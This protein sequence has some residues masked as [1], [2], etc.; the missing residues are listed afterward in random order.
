[1]SHA[2]S[3][4]HDLQ[5]PSDPIDALLHWLK[6]A[7]VA[8]IPEH[9]A[10]TLST[11]SFELQPSSRI[12]YFKGF[13]ADMT[14][15]RCP[16]FFTNFESR[17]SEDMNETPKVALLFYWPAQWRQVRIEGRVEKISYDESNTYF[18]TRARGSQ[19]GAW[20]SPQSHVIADRAALEDRVA[21]LE[22]KFTGQ[23]I[24]CPPFWG[25]WRVIPHRF[26]FWQGGESRLHDRLVYESDGQTPAW[27]Q[28][29]IAP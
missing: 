2:W 12:V 14:G 28:S 27:T 29:R 3:N 18:Q 4:D 6:E 24:A 11:V 25:G 8:K 22:K 16:R 1:M 15:Q 23:P 10:M 5:L 21:E 26:E 19:I 13:S 7:E 9:I 17:K 20:A